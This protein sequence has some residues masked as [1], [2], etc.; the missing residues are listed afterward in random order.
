MANIVIDGVTYSGT[1]SAPTNPYKPVEITR[2]LKK[3]GRL[4]EAADGSTS[5]VHRGFK[6]E[7]HIVWDKRSHGVTYNAV[8][9]LYAKTTTFS[10]TDTDGSSYTVLTAGDEPF[11]VP[12]STNAANVYSY[13][14]QIVL[15]EA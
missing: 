1:P 9:A 8:V 10:Y 12:I 4:L 2:K 14:V 13:G 15:R 7:F 3:I 5:W 11:E 6:W